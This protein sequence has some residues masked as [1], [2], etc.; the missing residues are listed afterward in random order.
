MK[1]LSFVL[2]S[3]ILILNTLPIPTMGLTTDSITQNSPILVFAGDETYI[4]GIFPEKDGYIVSGAT[5]FSNGSTVFIQK[6]SLSG[7]VIWNT[8]LGGKTDYVP[9]YARTDIVKSGDYFYVVGSTESSEIT[10]YHNGTCSDSSGNTHP[11]PDILVAKVDK[12]GNIIWRKA[13]GTENEDI[14]YGIAAD[15]NNILIAGYINRNTANKLYGS[16]YLMKIDTDGNVIWAKDYSSYD[17]AEYFYDVA[18]MGDKYIAVG[19]SYT[20]YKDITIFE[21]DKE[22]NHLWHKFSN[23]SNW[24][25]A[26]SVIPFDDSHFLIG[27]TGVGFTGFHD[28]MCGKYPCTDGYVAMYDLS[29]NKVWETSIGGSGEDRVYDLAIFDG[30]IYAVGYTKSEDGDF[31][32]LYTP[33]NCGSA[34]CSEGFITI[35]DGSG[36]KVENY[37]YDSATRK[38]GF[39]AIASTDNGYIAGGYTSESADDNDTG[40]LLPFIKEEN[41]PVPSVPTITKYPTTTAASEVSI[42]GTTDEYAKYVE[43]LVNDTATYTA[44]VVNQTFTATISLNKGQNTIKAR[45]CNDTGCSNFSDPITITYEKPQQIPAAP[46][47]NTLPGVVYDPE[48]TVSGKTDNLATYVK[49]FVNNKAYETS[50]SDQSFSVNVTLTP[51]ENTIYAQACNDAGCSEPSKAVKITYKASI[52]APTLNVPATTTFY[53]TDTVMISGNTGISGTLKVYVNGKEKVSTPVEAGYFEINVPVNHG[54]NEINAKICVDSTHCSALSNTITVIVKE[55][56]VIE[57]WIGKAYYR[58]NGAQSPMDASPF[59]MPPGRTV[60]PLRFVANGLGFD[61]HWNGKTREITITGKDINNIDTTII[62]SMPYQPDKKFKVGD[63]EVYPGNSKV[64]VI[65]NGERETID[66]TN[67]NGQ[68]MGIPVI[69]EGRTYVPVRFISEIFGAQVLWDGTEKKLTIIFER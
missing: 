52:P 3:L 48:I 63:K 44:N 5:K 27:G 7:E 66:L 68:N 13:Y 32:G 28:G 56:S 41:I 54:F 49:V 1:K 4:Y 62:L 20:N 21:V 46:T 19:M 23:Q 12:N 31:S 6:V 55:R 30:N 36:N 33:H 64:V 40:I 50:V 14:G 58:K 51:G 24:D 10:G 34:P 22:G 38:G 16:A 57:M 25:E 43:I 60:V 29:G 47:L 15:G 9:S 59:I 53:N 2:L 67:Y 35:I 37:V 18:V 26:Y 45:A 11:C 69:C 61:I 65:K 17:K 39:Y 42:K 8:Y